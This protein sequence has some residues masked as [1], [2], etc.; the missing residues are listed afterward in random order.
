VEDSH[1]DI[2]L[3]D[4]AS[5]RFEAMV[6]DGSDWRQSFVI[7]P[8]VLELLADVCGEDVLDAGCGPGFLTAEL[9][10]RGARVTGFDGSPKM[11]ELAQ[12]RMVAESVRATILQADLCLELA[13]PSETFDAIVC[14]MVLMDI[15]EIRTAL[16]EFRRLLRS[17]GRLVLSITHPAF[18]PQLWEKDAEG[19]PLWKK[20]VEDYL[21]V[22]S[23]IINMCGG[24][25][26]HHHRPL[27]YYVRELSSARFVVDAFVEPVPTFART[28]EKEYAWR[29][30]DF[31][32]MRALPR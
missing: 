14:S 19:R 30:P 12:R 27:S 22:R 15:P 4:A 9:A 7:R 28:P 26:R 13:L 11:I 24:P 18:F 17:T 20:P 1:D 16:A 10:R 25:T 5:E 2:E 3:W 6:A 23:E 29:V 21:T 32:V 31:A 8:A